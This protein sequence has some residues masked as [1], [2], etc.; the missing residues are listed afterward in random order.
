MNAVNTTKQQRTEGGK[1]KRKELTKAQSARCSVYH[2][3]TVV[4]F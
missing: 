4:T 3:N 2:L 1:R